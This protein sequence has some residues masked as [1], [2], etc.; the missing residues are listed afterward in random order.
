MHL[1]VRGSVFSLGDSAG[2]RININ[3]ESK[4]GWRL[5]TNTTDKYKISTKSASNALVL[6]KIVQNDTK[7]SASLWINPDLSGGVNGLGA[8]D[9]TDTANQRITPEFISFSISTGAT[10]FTILDEIRI[11]SDFDAVLEQ[12]SIKPKRFTTGD[13][14]VSS[15]GVVFG[16]SILFNQLGSE[17]SIR[18][19]LYNTPLKGKTAIITVVLKQDNTIKA[20]SVDEFYVSADGSTVAPMTLDT[21]ELEN[22][23]YTMYVYVWDKEGFVPL[24]S[25]HTMYV[26]KNN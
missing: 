16:E 21:T 23:S 19:P 9:V 22:D 25:P 3:W 10:T 20:C 13:I 24:I 18:A 4:K 7:T 5:K 14:S 11:A 15:G 12:T 26:V 2:G 8:A 6:V 1:P 17:V